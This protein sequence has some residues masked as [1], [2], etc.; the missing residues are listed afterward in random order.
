MK[1]K[2]TIFT[3]ALLLVAAAVFSLSSGA[4]ASTAPMGHAVYAPLVQRDTCPACAPRPTPTPRMWHIWEE[5][6]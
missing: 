1:T 5:Q 6:E 3:L 4:V 2:L